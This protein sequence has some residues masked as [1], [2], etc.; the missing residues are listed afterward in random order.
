M[1]IDVRDSMALQHLAIGRAQHA[2]VPDLDGV[3]E[4]CWKLGKEHVQPADKLPCEHAVSLELKE[5]GPGVLLKVGVPIGVQHM[6]DERLGVEEVGVLLAGSNPIT[7]MLGIDRN[8]D[9]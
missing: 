6:L 2:R 7:E 8:G 3:R 9:F 1:V 4:I 5:E